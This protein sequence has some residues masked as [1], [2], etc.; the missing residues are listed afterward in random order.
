MLKVGQWKFSPNVW[1]SLITVLLLPLFVYL[2]LWQLQRMEIKK[3]LENERQLA[4]QKMAIHLEELQDI[5]S[6]LNLLSPNSSDKSKR[7]VSTSLLYRQL[8]IKGKFLPD[9]SI[10]LD[11]QIL[12]GQPGYRVL[13]PFQPLNSHTLLLIDRGFIPWGAKRTELPLLPLM[14]AQAPAHEDSLSEG[15]LD[16]Q[17]SKHPNNTAVIHLLGIIT[18]LSQGLLLKDEP[19]PENLSWP[20]A[21]Q[22][23][24]YVKLA[25]E[26]KKP[27]YPFLLQL[28]QD[29]P[30]V[31]KTM[32][33]SLGLSPNRHLGYAIQWFTMAIAILIYYVVSQMS[34]I[35]EQ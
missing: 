4:T 13:T 32:P 18:Q 12:K 1:S 9:K 35:G 21:V 22:Q 34:R 29:N 11:N 17:N 8:A 23:L 20:L 27:L 19:I 14:T 2:G 28:P 26:L 30:Y 33:F 6:G 15:S 5:F 24:D 25:K 10:L 16:K 3:R 31:F 7:L